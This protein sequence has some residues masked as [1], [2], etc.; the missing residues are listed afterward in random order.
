MLQEQPAKL[1][2]MERSAGPIP[3]E[4]HKAF[5]A[6]GK[7][8][9]GCSVDTVLETLAP[10]RHYSVPKDVAFPVRACYFICSYFAR[11]GIGAFTD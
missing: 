9:V 10:G 4:F 1:R 2:Q 11:F 7:L 3:D 8:P 6:C 5:A